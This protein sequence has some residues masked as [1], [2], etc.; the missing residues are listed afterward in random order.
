[1]ISN[2]GDDVDPLVD[3]A[4]TISVLNGEVNEAI[5]APVSTPR[6]LDLVVWLT[7][8]LAC[9]ILHIVIINDVGVG[10]A[11]ELVINKLLV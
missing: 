8:W 6:V 11:A 1:M 3:S 10:P 5:M 9:V 2:G 7:R 4:S